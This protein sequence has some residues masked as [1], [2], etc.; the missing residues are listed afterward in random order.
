MRRLCA[1]SLAIGLVVVF[2]GIARAAL[3]GVDIGTPDPA[4]SYIYDPIAGT[5][6]VTGSGHDIWDAADDFQFAYEETPISDPEFVL[7]AEVESFTGTGN[8]AWQ[9][10]GLMVRDTLDPDSMHSYGAITSGNGYSHQGRYTTGTNQ[11]INQQTQGLTAPI[12]LR[13]KRDGDT[14]TSYTSD[15]GVGWVQRGQ[16]TYATPMTDPLYYGL[17]VTSHQD[18][19]LST[20][21]FKKLRVLRYRRHVDLG[22][23][24]EQLGGRRPLE[25]R[26]RAHRVEP[27]R[28]AGR[29]RDRH[30]AGRRRVRIDGPERRDHHRRCHDPYDRR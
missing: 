5:H 19:T 25:R 9:K 15:D 23:D 21:V 8:N 10:A 6:T 14:F 1:V 16:Y 11:N 30:H 26:Q 3:V 28:G 12:W 18:G 7:T 29:N 27:H 4:G 22:W 17:A 24:H 20:A 2:G 13:L